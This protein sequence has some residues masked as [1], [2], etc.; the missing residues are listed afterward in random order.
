MTRVLLLWPGSVGASGGSF[1]CPQLVGLATYLHAHT[2]ADVH[3]RDLVFERALA[4]SSRRS[5]SLAQ[6]FLGDDGRGYDVIGVA[7]YSSFDWLPCTALAERARALLPHAVIVAGGYHASARPDE[8]I[9]DGSPFDVCIVGEGE[10]PFTRVVLSVDGGAPMRQQILGSEPI[11][12]LDELPLTDWSYLDR[13]R[14]IARRHASQAQLYLS[15]GCPFDCAFCMER[16]KR[17]VR[18]RAYS[19]ERAIDEVVRLHAWLDLRSWTLFVTDALFG[20]KASWRRAF[21]AELARRALPIDTTWLLLR[22]DLVEDDDLALLRDANCSVGFGLESGD[23]EQLAIIRKTGRIEDHLVRM[24]EI[25]AWSLE[26]DLAWGANVIVGH[27]GETRASM[28]RSARY[29]RALFLSPPATTGFLSVD[30]YRFY[31]GSPIDHERGAWEHRFGAR[32][33]APTWWHEGDPAFLSEWCD[34]SRELDFLERES[35]QD[36]LFGPIL[37]E[38]ESRY[39]HRGR[40]REHFLRSI[41]DQASTRRTRLDTLGRYFAWRAWTGHRIEAARELLA[42]TDLAS[43][44]R[45]GREAA[46]P[47]IARLAQLPLDSPIL[48]A[49]REV[50]RERFVPIDAVAES[51]RDE[52]IAIGEVAVSAM[53]AYALVHRLAGITAGLRVLDLGSGSGYGGALLGH[54]VGAAGSV[55]GVEVDPELVR[56]SRVAL[57]EGS[58]VEV[59]LGDA[60]EPSHWTDDLDVVVAG[61]AWDAIPFALITRLREG[62]IVVLPVATAPDEQRLAR[63]EAGPTPRVTWH[64]RVRYVTVRGVPVARPRAESEDALVPDKQRLPVLR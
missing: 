7:I 15:R 62:A 32:F 30:P 24:H 38:I 61:F 11:E 25:A 4:A 6:V 39:A 36:T 8:V 54:V 64:D 33:H 12:D 60:R 18:W 63:I 52:P 2:K 5:F 23:P 31:P 45:E 37:A 21:L 29:L 19:V 40:A 51:A 17:E 42:H 46:L 27:P 43:L 53:H 14:G 49:I 41:R 28:E 26:H 47:S 34:P 44:A 3:V 13:Y 9:A 10:L 56:A 20:M 48:D 58:R 1:G 50:P 57:G 55:R 35:L 16:A 59:F 22:I